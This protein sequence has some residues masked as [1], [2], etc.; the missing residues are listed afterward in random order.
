MKKNKVEQ[1]MKDEINFLNKEKERWN[2]FFQ[3]RLNSAEPNVRKVSKILI[4]AQIVA[5]EVCHVEFK[6]KDVV[7]GRGYVMAKVEWKGEQFCFTKQ[8]KGWNVDGY[9]KSPI[10][11]SGMPLSDK[12]SLSLE[13]SFVMS[14]LLDEFNLSNTIY[15]YNDIQFHNKSLKKL[16]FWE[17]IIV[18]RGE[19]SRKKYVTFLKTLQT[20]TL[21]LVSPFYVPFVFLMLLTQGK[22]LE[23]KMMLPINLLI[24]LVSSPF[25][26]FFEKVGDKISFMHS[27]NG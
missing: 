1:F 5:L 21:M 18:N 8:F 26:L 17:K 7:H 15:N 10:I 9:F 12:F 2:Q 22:L 13:E 20:V 14:D 6:E 23:L 3:E 11:F 19:K 27:L 24:G 25:V 16:S 4:E